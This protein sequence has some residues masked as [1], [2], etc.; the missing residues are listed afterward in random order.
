MIELDRIVR[1]HQNFSRATS[2]FFYA[3]S[4]AFALNFFWEPGGIYASGITGAAQLVATI[5][6]HWAVPLST[7]VMLTVLNAPLFILAWRKIGHHFTIFTMLSVILSS[8]LIKVIVVKTVINDPIICAIFGAI[9]NGIGTGLALRNGISTGGLDILGI[10]LRKKTG[11]SV[12]T[13]NIAFNVMI[14][15]AAGFV[16]SWP[17]AFYSALGIFI[18]GR[19]IDMLYTRDRRL[20]VMIVTSR[21]KAVITQIQN[22]MPRGITIVHDAEGAYKHQ[23]KT[24]LFTVISQFEIYD[25]ENA[26]K[27]A[28]EHAFVSITSAVKIIGRF[29]EPKQE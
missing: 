6:K 13:I 28:D 24:I 3:L 27:L 22:E 10:T 15:I 20:Q 25:L 5:T 1:R 7:P 19:V 18:N 14:L 29:Y 21:P 17:H 16:Y 9:F 11:R 12:G 23:E 26:M 8:I 2:A 4:V